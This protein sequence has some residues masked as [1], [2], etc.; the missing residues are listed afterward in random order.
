MR[1]LA[2]GDA[3]GAPFESL[4]GWVNPRLEGW[5]GAL[6][7]GGDPELWPE[8]R[9]AGSTTDDT[10]FACAL[11]RSLIGGEYDPART[12]KAYAELY[13]ARYESSAGGIGGTLR[14]ACRRL[15][16][17]VSWHEAAVRE[18]P[19]DPAGSYCGSGAAMRAAP[20]GMRKARRRY[21]RGVATLDAGITHY[22]PEAAVGSAVV[23]AGVARLCDGLSVREAELSIL[24]MLREG[25]HGTRV[26]RTFRG[27][28]P[29]DSS[30]DV[31]ALVGLAWEDLRV[32]AFDLEQG[33]TP[34]GVFERAC[35][36][37]VQRLG[38]TDT[39]A[40]VL[41]AWLGAWLG[42]EGLPVEARAV[43][44]YE[45]LAKLDE[46]LP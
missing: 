21:V 41:G 35:I 15:V 5:Q 29:T 34:Q 45:E 33:G 6:L 22:H 28:L 19:A 16:A 31:A 7:E 14:G 25:L 23:A 46:E 13:R 36:R 44:N 3:L 38:D 2:Y 4:R 12:A 1:G 30:G 9:S 10:A 40:S 11:A 37:T 27:E 20:L 18:D 42:E 39:R 8:G 24:D 26:A 17:G 32:A 43:A